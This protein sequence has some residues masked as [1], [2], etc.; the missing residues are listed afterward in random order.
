VTGLELA[1]VYG[2]G[3]MTEHAGQDQDEQSGQFHLEA[4]KLK[5]KS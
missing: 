1:P 2:I 5:F 3:R 4:K